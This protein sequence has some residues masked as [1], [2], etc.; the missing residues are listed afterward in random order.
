M[1]EDHNNP[2]ETSAASAPVGPASPPGDHPS[3][4]RALLQRRSLWLIGALL[5][6]LAGALG[7][8]W[9]FGKPKIVYTTAAV[10]RG[11]IESTVAAAGIVQPVTF[12]D[13]GAQT[14]GVWIV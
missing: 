5:V 11:D 14:S 7:Y 9:L 10:E 3:K 12:V 2:E 6:V 8:H 1:E 4:S 13:V